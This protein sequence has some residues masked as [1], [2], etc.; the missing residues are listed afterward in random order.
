M[1]LELVHAAPETPPLGDFVVDLDGFEGPLDLLLELAR[2]QK[3]DLKTISLVVLADQYLAYLEAARAARLEIAAEYLVM[4]AWLAYLKSQL[5]LPPAERPA[6]DAQAL[7][8]Q[9]TERLRRLEAIRAAVQHLLDRP[10]LGRERLPRGEVEPVPIEVRPRWTGTLVELLQCYGR[11]MRRREP[12]R[13]RLPSRSLLTVEAAMQRLSRMLTGHDWRELR[14]FL[15]TS[16]QDEL[17]RRAAVAASLIAMLELARTG[18]IELQQL[19]PF[20]PIMVRRR[21]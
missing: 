14:H 9:L 1:T 7:A 4:A 12:A 2:A 11:A 19:T 13:V 21:A 15:P 8:E 5:L 3:I 16:L 6:E 17:E 20:G 18:V 10:R